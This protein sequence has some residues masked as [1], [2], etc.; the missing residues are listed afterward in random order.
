M[1]APMEKAVDQVIAVYDSPVAANQVLKRISDDVSRAHP[2]RARP[3]PI[4][5]NQGQQLRT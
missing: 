2:L 5:S 3:S 4:Y 1:G